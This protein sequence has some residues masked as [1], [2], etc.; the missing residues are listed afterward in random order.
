MKLG[1]GLMSS[2][3]ARRFIYASDDKIQTRCHWQRIRKHA[4]TWA[5]GQYEL[6]TPKICSINGAYAQGSSMTQSKL[7]AANQIRSLLGRV[8]IGPE[9][10]KLSPLTFEGKLLG[11]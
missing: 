2:D 10:P 3:E 7:T 4:R 9:R 11:P 5:E 6:T 1:G 8:G